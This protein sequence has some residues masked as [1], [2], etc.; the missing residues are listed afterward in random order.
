MTSDLGVTG[1]AVSVPSSAA[2]EEA[3]QVMERLHIHRV[4]VVDADGETPIGLLSI[5]DLVR[6]IAEE[7]LE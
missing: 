3:A 7:G 1:P 6:V 4:V 5:S 2:F